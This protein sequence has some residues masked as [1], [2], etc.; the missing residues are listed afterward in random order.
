MLRSWA[1]G[2]QTFIAAHPFRILTL[3]A[4]ATPPSYILTVV[5]QSMNSDR[6]HSGHPSSKSNVWV[7][8]KVKFFLFKLVNIGSGFEQ[9]VPLLLEAVSY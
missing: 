3:T 7:V 2:L 1:C 9:A 5:N 8:V 6:L 4:G